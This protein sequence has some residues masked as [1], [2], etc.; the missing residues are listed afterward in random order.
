MKKNEP[1]LLSFSFLLDLVVLSEYIHQ[2][3]IFG[4][5]YVLNIGIYCFL[6]ASRISYFGIM[7]FNI[8]RAFRKIQGI[9]FNCLSY[10][11]VKFHL[12]SCKY[13]CAFKQLWGIPIFSICTKREVIIPLHISLIT[14]NCNLLLS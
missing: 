12:T 4:I 3:S 11:L 13:I 9:A 2:S 5:F 14:T 8:R 6:F 1:T 10:S 7:S